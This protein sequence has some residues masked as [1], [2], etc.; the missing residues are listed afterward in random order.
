MVREGRISQHLERPLFGFEYPA[1]SGHRPLRQTR[2]SNLEGLIDKGSNSSANAL[3]QRGIHAV[4]GA[5]LFA[6]F[7]TTEGRHV[8]RRK[9]RF[10]DVEGRQ[11]HFVPRPLAGVDPSSAVVPYVGRA[12]LHFGEG[13]GA[14]LHAITLRG[15]CHSFRCTKP[16]PPR[17][18]EADRIVGRGKPIACSRRRRSRPNRA[19][20]RQRRAGPRRR[21]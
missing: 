14:D 21:R 10:E 5:L 3:K 2:R 15:A 9:G 20:R 1:F 17:G 16:S 8:F 11:A 12:R 19:G 7:E 13:Q 18:R 4:M 6:L